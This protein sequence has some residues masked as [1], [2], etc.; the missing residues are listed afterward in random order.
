VLPD[1]PCVALLSIALLASSRMCPCLLDACTHEG[2]DMHT[3]GGQQQDE[4]W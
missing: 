3:H 2:L 4:R 1:S